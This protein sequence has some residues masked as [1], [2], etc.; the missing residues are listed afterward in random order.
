MFVLFSSQTIF[1]LIINPPYSRSSLDASACI[2]YSKKFP[3][4]FVWSLFVQLFFVFSKSAEHFFKH[5]GNGGPAHLYH[6]AH[7]VLLFSHIL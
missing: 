3:I 5:H 2:S 1:S 7:I 4:V 6:I